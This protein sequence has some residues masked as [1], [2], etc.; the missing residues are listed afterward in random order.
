MYKRIFFRKGSCCS[1]NDNDCD[2]VVI[3]NRGRK[4]FES[5]SKGE[6]NYQ[7]NSIQEKDGGGESITASA[8]LGREF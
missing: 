3:R 4:R 5:F 7:G 2:N 6:K 8:V 1:E